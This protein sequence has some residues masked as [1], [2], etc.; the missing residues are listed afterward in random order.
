MSCC[1]TA[2]GKRFTVCL[3]TVTL[4]TTA[5]AEMPPGVAPEAMTEAA[6]VEDAVRCN[7]LITF[8]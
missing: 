8:Y 3:A 6:A 1:T 2:V 7:S 4:D 5:E